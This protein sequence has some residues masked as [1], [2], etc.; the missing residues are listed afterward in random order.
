MLLWAALVLVAKV[1]V[2]VW[3][4]HF[5]RV[6][7]AL[8]NLQLEGTQTLPARMR[9]T[10][11]DYVAHVLNNIRRFYPALPAKTVLQLATE[12]G[13][14]HGFVLLHKGLMATHCS[15]GIKVYVNSTTE[16]RRK[17]INK[18]VLGNFTFPVSGHR[19][20][21]FCANRCTCGEIECVKET[22]LSVEV[23]S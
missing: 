6:Q 21:D 12:L 2:I 11:G 4:G 1:Q 19:C 3:K 8:W 9:N 5:I 13:K 16:C 20:C 18:Y 22:Q 23:S 17:W 15:K 14:H 10:S 7:G